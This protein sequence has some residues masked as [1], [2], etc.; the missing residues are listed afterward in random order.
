VIDKRIANDVL[1]ASLLGGPIVAVLIMTQA[2]VV[3]WW[4]GRPVG[5]YWIGMTAV[6]AVLAFLVGALIALPLA[7]VVTLPL[8]LLAHRFKVISPAICGLVGAFSGWACFALIRIVNGVPVTM[9]ASRGL[10]G[11]A[12][13]IVAGFV[14]GLAYWRRTRRIASEG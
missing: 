14:A 9:S 10:A 13:F 7:V 3:E 11:D 6:F 5:L 12:T 1:R 2:A 8:I 4:A